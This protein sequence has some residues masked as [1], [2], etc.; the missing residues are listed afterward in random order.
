MNMMSTPKVV[1]WTSN[2][3]MLCL[4]FIG[5]T[6]AQT[7]ASKSSASLGNR[8]AR[9][10]WMPDNGD[11]TYT[12]PI[13][14][15]DYSDP[16][17]IR[18]GDD[19]Y[20]TSSSFSH[21]PGL[22][23]LHSKDLV[24]WT[25][26]GHAVSLYPIE[27][28]NSPQHGN[29]IWAP[30]IRYH[31]GEF[32][33][34]FGDPDNGIFL[35]KTKNPSG[36]WQP[37]QLVHKA[38]GWIDPCPL[39][40]DDGNAY[41]VHAW[42]NSR[43]GIKSILTLNKMNAEGTQILDDGITVFDG[44]QHHPTIEGPKIYKRHGYY[45][46]F[47]PAGGVKPGWQTVLRSKSAYGPYEDRIVLQQGSTSINGPHQGAW[48]ETQ[49]SESWFIHF[50]DRG[51]YGRIVH[52]E[53]MRWIDDWPAIGIDYDKNGIGEPVS[54]YQKPDVGRVSALLAPQTA[55]EFGTNFLGLQ[56]QWESNPKP[57]WFSLSAR[58]D[59]LRLYAQTLPD[60][61][62]NLWQVGNV[63]GQKIPAPEFIATARVQFFPRSVGEK[64]GLVVFGVAYTYVAIER[65][66]RGYRLL[67]AVCTNAERGTIEQEVI[68]IPIANPAIYLRLTMKGEAVCSFGYSLDGKRFSSLD[69]QFVAVPGKWV[70][71]KIGLFVESMAGA[72][73]RGY[74]DFDWVRFER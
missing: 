12:N 44:R 62:D 4:F 46:I 60:S 31:H 66:E 33:I 74:A 15:A 52:L 48:V 54:R 59:W 35:T 16:D 63:L 30:S 55:D 42:A 8:I 41:L 13:I 72:Q 58:K 70:G 50:Q 73:Q 40:D 57:D 2:C 67:Q 1:R 37:L 49:K 17:V 21:F 11:G 69:Q 28:F 23:I 38:K 27:S 65:G 25:I 14:Y 19:F 51:P 5:V 45:Y 22:P 34:Y 26:I 47:A 61:A 53:P 71:A 3:L 10:V 20:M 32:Y 43:S 39:W 6:T 68:A 64:V 29:G 9:P 18:V 24:N 56:W 36:P 7:A